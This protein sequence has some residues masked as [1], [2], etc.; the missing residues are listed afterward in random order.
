MVS[1]GP[2]TRP[3]EQWT[4]TLSLWILRIREDLIDEEPSIWVLFELLC[5]QSIKLPAPMEE[6]RLPGSAL[7]ALVFAVEERMVSFSPGLCAVSGRAEN[8]LSR[9]GPRRRRALWRRAPQWTGTWRAALL[10]GQLPITAREC[11]G[12]PKKLCS[13]RALCGVLQWQAAWRRWRE[14]LARVWVGC[15]QREV[16]ADEVGHVEQKQGCG[17]APA[18][19]EREKAE[20][21][22]VRC[23]VVVTARGGAVRCLSSQAW[24]WVGVGWQSTK[25]S[26]GGQRE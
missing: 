25:S 21:E 3:N 11:V 22:E 4:R 13:G 23:A 17:Q 19:E 16:Q 2:A 9:R 20:T 5:C 26:H 6:P 10:V 12:G 7:P 14:K 1:D 8:V 24:C 18:M 15:L